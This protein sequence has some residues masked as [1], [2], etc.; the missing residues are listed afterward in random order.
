MKRPQKRKPAR[1]TPKRISRDLEH[2]AYHEAGHAVIGRILGIVCGDVTIIPDYRKR[3]RGVA[4]ARSGPLNVS[5]DWD[6]RGKLRW[7]VSAARAGI[8]CSMAG[9]EAELIRFASHY[10]GDGDDEL[11]IALKRD[12][13]GIPDHQIDYLRRKSRTMLQRHWL[14]VEHVAKALL[15]ARTLTSE[16]ID[17]LV[18][19]KTTP[20]E[21][22]SARRIE[23]A[24]KPDRDRYLTMKVYVERR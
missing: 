6:E 11:Q 18:N 7:P 15:V 24:R 3:T 9:K 5:T 2:T 19:E 17:A 1:R 4:I 20:R 10:G 13:Y 16:Q 23:A 8:M 21:H 12:D 14:K 22:E